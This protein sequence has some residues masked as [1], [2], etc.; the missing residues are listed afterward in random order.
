MKRKK[1]EKKPNEQL[2]KKRLAEKIWQKKKMEIG[3]EQKITSDEKKWLNR[4][5]NVRKLHYENEDEDGKEGSGVGAYRK[6]G[7]RT[8]FASRTLVQLTRPGMHPDAQEGVRMHRVV[9]V[10]GWGDMK[11]FH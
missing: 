4:T 11:T 5:K 9:P 6:D 3:R 1:N 8:N 2:Q 7:G 10:W